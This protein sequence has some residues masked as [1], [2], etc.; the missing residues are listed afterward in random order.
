MD[1]G[2]QQRDSLR[3]RGASEAEGFGVPPLVGRIRSF[4]SRILFEAFGENRLM[5]QVEARGMTEDR[6]RR[7]LKAM[8]F[9]ELAALER[10]FPKTE[11]A[12]ERQTSLR[13]GTEKTML[14]R[15]NQN[16]I[17]DELHPERNRTWESSVADEVP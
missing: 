2:S 6:F 16:V 10:Q 9:E 3:L 1:G 12:T 17:F 11:I 4:P 15:K 7:V 5:V 13:D 14:V 8:N